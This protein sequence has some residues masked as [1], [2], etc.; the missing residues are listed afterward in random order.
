MSSHCYQRLWNEFIIQNCFQE[1]NMSF[2]NPFRCYYNG[3]MNK[4]DV[5]CL[6]EALIAVIFSKFP[7]ERGTGNKIFNVVKD[8]VWVKLLITKSVSNPRLLNWHLPGIPIHCFSLPQTLVFLVFLAS[9]VTVSLLCFPRAVFLIHFFFGGGDIVFHQYMPCT[10][11]RNFSFSGSTVWAIYMIHRAHDCIE[12]SGF[13]LP[14][15]II[16]SQVQVGSQGRLS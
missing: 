4:I 10:S 5:H 12:P 8:A 1:P 15:V 11:T 3:I 13:L 2:N 14:A 9:N 16:G 7:K 6:T